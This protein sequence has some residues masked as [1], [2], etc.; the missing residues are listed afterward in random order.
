MASSMAVKIIPL[1]VSLDLLFAYGTP[2]IFAFNLF[3][4][5]FRANGIPEKFGNS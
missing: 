5:V 3:G 1:F 4:D 2:N